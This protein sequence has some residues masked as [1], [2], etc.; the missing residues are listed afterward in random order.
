MLEASPAAYGN[1]YAVV[2]KDIAAEVG[3]FAADIDAV[4]VEHTGGDLTVEFLAR[5]GYADPVL[6][7]LKVQERADL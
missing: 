2:A 6:N 1:A 5:K 3:S 7:T 4:V